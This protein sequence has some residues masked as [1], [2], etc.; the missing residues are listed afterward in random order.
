[1]NELAFAI[2][3]FMKVEKHGRYAVDAIKEISFLLH[4]FIFIE[5]IL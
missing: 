4:A 2:V 5:H 3:I 1:M